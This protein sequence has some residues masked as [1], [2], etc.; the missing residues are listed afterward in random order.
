MYT[1][2]A[3]RNCRKSEPVL[4]R[5]Q[6]SLALVCSGK[7]NLRGKGNEASLQPSNRF[8]QIKNQEKLNY[9]WAMISVTYRWTGFSSF[10]EVLLAPMFLCFPLHHLQCHNNITQHFNLWQ[11]CLFKHLTMLVYL[12]ISLLQLPNFVENRMPSK[13]FESVTIFP[14]IGRT[15]VSV[16]WMV[17]TW[18]ALI[19]CLQIPTVPFLVAAV[20]PTL[21]LFLVADKELWPHCSWLS[22]LVIQPE[23]SQSVPPERSRPVALEER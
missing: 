19:P 10:E 18:I 13:G 17:F 4:H 1:K 23:W 12:I 20:C 2:Q 3:E 8:N 21:L 5:I 14:E 11:M 9:V 16:L 6:R 15:A 22:C 7:G